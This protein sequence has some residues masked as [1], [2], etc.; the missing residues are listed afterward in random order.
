MRHTNK[1]I[2]KLTVPSLLGV[3]LFLVPVSIGG[4]QEILVGRIGDWLLAAL[5]DLFPPL[6]VGVA[7][8]SAAGALWHR[9]FPVKWIARSETLNRFF[10][11]GRFWLAVR[12]VGA[13]IAVMTC[14]R[15]GPE[16]IWSEDTGW[17]MLGSILPNCAVWYIVGGLL[18]PLLTDYGLLDV[19]GAL[20]TRIARPLFGI[21]GRAVIDCLTSWIGSSVCGTYL[22]I[23]QYEAGYYNARQT[24]II[25][26][27]FSLLSISFC[28]MIASMLGLGGMFGKFYLTICIAGLLCAVVDIH[29]WPIRSVPESFDAVSGKQVDNGPDPAQNPLRYGWNKALERA[30]GAPGPA[31]LAKKGLVNA[32]DLLVSTIPAVMAFGT[33]ALIVANYTPVFQYLGLP[34]GMYLRLFQV[35]EAMTAGAAMLVGFADQFIPVVIAS[36]MSSMYTRFVLGCM[37]ILQILYISD[38][39]ALILTSRVPFPLWKMFV[40]FLE[41]IVICV[42]VVVLCAHWF[43]IA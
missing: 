6:L 9:L 2:L 7:V 37:A 32:C 34:L 18:L 20:F 10:S 1:T 13:V 5:G 41:R 29:L 28:S 43:G 21:P 39:G 17:S 35:P 40:I 16:A 27:N 33:I 3:A 22:T 15:L 23:S 19:F 14:F 25:L 24:I 11:P 31:A 42:P 8:I 26:S 36:S 4:E 12:V 30:D 38:V